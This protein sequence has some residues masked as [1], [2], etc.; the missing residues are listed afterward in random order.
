VVKPI[1]GSLHEIARTIGA[2]KAHRH[3]FGV[4]DQVMKEEGN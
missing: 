4:V 2:R 1:A 3:L